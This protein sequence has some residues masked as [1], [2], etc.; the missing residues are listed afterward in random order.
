MIGE[1]TQ[2]VSEFG[3]SEL[4]ILPSYEES[5]CENGEKNSEDYDTCI[6]CEKVFQRIG[7][8]TIVGVMSFCNECNGKKNN[9]AVGNKVDTIRSFL[10]QMSTLND[11]ESIKNSWKIDNV[12]TT[13]MKKV[14]VKIEKKVVN[15]M[16]LILVARRNFNEL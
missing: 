7:G 9:E 3:F 13:I 11:L 2:T 1:T 4:N 15:I 16:T 6:D 12:I 10:I 14:M 8:G 5:D